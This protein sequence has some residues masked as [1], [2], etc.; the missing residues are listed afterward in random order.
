M[1]SFANFGRLPC[2]LLLIACL[3]ACSM[4]GREPKD[5]GPA[6]TVEVSHIP[7]AQPQSVVRTRAGNAESYRV[8]GKTY[9]VLTDS[10]GYRKRGLASWYGTKFH[11]QP[12]ANGEI[13]N[14]YAMTAAHKTL[15]IPSYVRVTNLDNGRSIIVRI[16][17]RGPF[18]GNRLIDLSYVAARKLGITQHGTAWVDIEDVTPLSGSDTPKSLP[19]SSNTVATHQKTPEAY[20]VSTGKQNDVEPGFGQN[21]YLQ[22]GAFQQRSTAVGLQAEIMGMLVAPVNIFIG[23]DDLHRVKLGPVDNEKKLLKWQRILQ[24]NGIGPGFI[25]RR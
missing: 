18:V 14:M 9:R 19:A 22:L 4:I 12:T 11:G 7:N 1:T 5:G 10:R 23:D 2:L 17:D 13:Y 3:S 15:P 8:H 21:L 24:D 6:H 25:V 20:S 16:N